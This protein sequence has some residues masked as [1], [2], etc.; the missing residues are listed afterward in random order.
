MSRKNDEFLHVNI[1][2]LIWF[3]FVSDDLSAMDSPF[4]LYCHIKGALALLYYFVTFCPL[5]TGWGSMNS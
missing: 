1:F 4:F 5:V 3:S 2:N